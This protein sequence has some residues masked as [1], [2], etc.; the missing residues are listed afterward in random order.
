MMNAK[1]KALWL[2]AL[3]SSE[4]MQGKGFLHQSDGTKCCLGV[5]CS[6]AGVPAE[7]AEDGTVFLYDKETAHLSFR[8]RVQFGIDFSQ[9]DNLELMND[10]DSMSFAEIA[11]YIEANL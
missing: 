8:L 11:D 1:Y 6:A 2:L 3:R 10:H 4:H 9:M 5:L 7:L